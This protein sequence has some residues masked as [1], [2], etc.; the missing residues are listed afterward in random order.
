MNPTPPQG[1]RPTPSQKPNLRLAGAAVAILALVAVGLGVALLRAPAPPAP[2]APIEGAVL[3]PSVAGQFYPG[4]PGELR[5]EVS[6]LLAASPQRGLKRVRAIIAPHAGYQ[7]SG[8]VAAQA[9]REIDPSFRTAL[10]LADN[11]NPDARH[12]GAS[13]PDAGGMAIPGATLPISPIAAELRR[14][15]PQL[16]TC[17]PPAHRTHV[18]EVHLPF[19]QAIKGWPQAPDYAILPMVLGSMSPAD[20]RQLA[21]ALD[22]AAPKDGIFIASTDLSHFLDDASARQIDGTT[23]QSM[24]AVAPE[25]L[26]PGSCC[27][28]ASVATVLELAKD[29]AWQ[30]HFLGYRNS[31]DASGDTSRVVGYTAIA[32][33]EPFSIDPDTGRALTDYARQVVEFRLRSD[34]CP[35][36]DDALLRAH[37][38]LRE[39][40]GVFVTIKKHG[41]LRGCIGS[42]GASSPIC[43]GIREFAIKAAFE[44]PRF[45][46]VSEPEL[47]DL[48]YS[49][50][51]LTDP[52][53][54]NAP[55]E[56]FP[57]RLRPGIDGVI[58]IVGD[59][60][61]TFLPQVWQEIPKPE[62]FLAHLCVKQGSPPDAWRRADT[63]LLTYSAL[64]FGEERPR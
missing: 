37:P 32:F 57:S 56:E 29:H 5:A 50:S 48:K 44:D 39:K 41:Q 21:A 4:N 2:P 63:R 58:L 53:P 34:R 28:P 1:P 11:H 52:V 45:P 9:Y 35:D 15:H 31:S 14:T 10:I 40:H 25:K 47:P 27:G 55:P 46:P 54:L 30:P 38:E 42:L 64:V 61:S 8:A 59:R 62:E 51:V 60:S 36:L 18:V 6:R 26:S 17:E 23:I 22:A 33:T 49:V 20:T 13:I 43:D 12:S 3:P 7:F 16:F 24:L 19:L